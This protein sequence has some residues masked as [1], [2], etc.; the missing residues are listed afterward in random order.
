M[1]NNQ[2]A[3]TSQLRGLVAVHAVKDD[4]LGEVRVAAPAEDPRPHELLIVARVAAI[5]QINGQPWRR[6][7]LLLTRR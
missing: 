4:A 6:V 5:M 2:S 7:K 1:S 3:A